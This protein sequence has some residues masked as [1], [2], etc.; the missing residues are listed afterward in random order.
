MVTLQNDQLVIEIN[1]HGAELCSVVDRKSGYEF[2]WQADEEYWARHAPVLFPIIGR[3][4]DDKYEYQGKE[5]HMTQH[6]FARDSEFH[7]EEAN[8]NAAVFS[9]TYDEETLKVY[10]FEFKLLIKYLLHGSNLTVTYEVINLS[11]SEVMYYNVGGHPAFNVSHSQDQEGEL[12][13]EEVYFEIQPERSHKRLPISADG[14]IQLSKARHVEG[15][16]IKLTHETFK[17]DA[18]VYELINQSEIVLQDQAENV[19]IRFKPNRMNYIGVWSPYPKK[20]S[21]VCLEPWTGFADTE[22]ST[23]KL[24]EKDGISFLDVN[25]KM[26]HDYTMN[27][28]KETKIQ[29]IHR[30]D[31]RTQ[32]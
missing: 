31:A 17:E 23:G 24:A 5:Y 16:R 12:D 3:L 25:E 1:T 2:L 29:S 28:L 30:W 26:I 32:L 15:D 11:T 13:F 21:F 19:E 7:L 4:K 27:F 6:G 14:L 18:L 20:A 10:P 9:L 8:A 22:R